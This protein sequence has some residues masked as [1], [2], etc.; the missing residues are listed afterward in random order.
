M[1]QAVTDPHRELC[2]GEPDAHTRV[3]RAVLVSPL[4]AVLSGRL[5]LISVTGR[6][7]GRV[8]LP[9]RV[10]A[11]GDRV[12]INVGLPQRRCWWRSL[13]DGAPVAIRLR[14]VRRTGR[15]Q[16][17]G[18]DGVVATVQLDPPIDAQAADPRGPRSLAPGRDDTARGLLSARGELRTLAR[19]GAD[20]RPRQRST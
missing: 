9:G 5:A 18:R 12:V 3:V 19:R 1:A 14:G 16:A 10:P 2:A 15:T 11:D 17:T 7:S 13:L 8:S 4:D 6:R 20:I